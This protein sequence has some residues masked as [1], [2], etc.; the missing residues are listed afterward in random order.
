MAE[1]D[2]RHVSLDDGRQ[3]EYLWAVADDCGVPAPEGHMRALVHLT[4][5][6]ELAVVPVLLTPEHFAAAGL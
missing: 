2:W 4:I 3:I 5:D 6:G 1:G